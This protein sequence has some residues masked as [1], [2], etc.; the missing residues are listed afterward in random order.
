MAVAE[1]RRSYAEARHVADVREL[2]AV[3]NGAADEAEL[4]SSEGIGVRVRVGGGWGF[5]ATRD[6]SREG[7]EAALARALAIAEAQPAGPATPL[8]PVEPVTGH[9]SS[10]HAVDPFDVALE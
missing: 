2:L 3:N 8:T 1:G 9:W 10:P 6:V 5:A 4:E 7:A